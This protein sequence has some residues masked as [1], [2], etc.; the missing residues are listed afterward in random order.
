M[1]WKHYQ[2]P[3]VLQRLMTLGSCVAIQKSVNL[4]RVY[5][6][7]FTTPSVQSTPL[8]RYDT[9]RIQPSPLHSIPLLRAKRE[10][11]RRLS[12]RFARSSGEQMRGGCIRRLAL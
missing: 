1:D 4:L 10:E 2:T 6:L 12:S 8:L 11:S 9:P 5:S 7:F 3:N